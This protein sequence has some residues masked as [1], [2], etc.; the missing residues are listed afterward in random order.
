MDGIM[1]MIVGRNI[2][3]GAPADQVRVHPFEP[4]GDPTPANHLY[5][6]IR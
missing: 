3:D 2:E 4:G 5:G 1:G 6:A